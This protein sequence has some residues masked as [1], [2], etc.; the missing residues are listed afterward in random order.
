MSTLATMKTR[1]ANELGQRVDLDSEIATAISDAIGAY[2]NETFWFN[3]K[4]SLTF[5]TVVDQQDYGSAANTLI[6]GI[7][8]FD[9]VKL[10]IGTIV[11]DLKSVSAEEIEDD[12]SGSGSHQPW[13]Y[14][15]LNGEIRL[16]PVPSQVWTVRVAGTISV[17]GPATDVEAAN[18]WMVEA[19]R[20]IRSR[21]KWELGMHVLSDTDLA[22]RSAESV[23]EALAQLRKI[24]ATKARVNKGQVVAVEF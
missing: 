22:T 16:Y 3:R 8:K 20:L 1:I 18:P 17:P 15:Y 2:V 24:S 7:M 23:K 19:E 5:S 21:A 11:F 9:Y 12:T 10:I 14:T 6:P 13:K 4:R